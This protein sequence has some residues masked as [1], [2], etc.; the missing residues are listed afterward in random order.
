MYHISYFTINDFKDGTIYYSWD[1]T[2]F[3]RL[4][5]DGWID[6]VHIGKGRYRDHNKYKVSYK[7]KMLINRIYKMLIGEESIPESSKRNTILKRKSYIDKVYSQAI[8]KFNKQKEKQRAILTV[9]PTVSSTT[10]EVTYTASNPGNGD[11]IT[12]VVLRDF[13]SSPNTTS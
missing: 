6:K 7:G 2:R 11:I 12:V 9:T 5:R 3:Y 1:K 13:T 4:Q 10:G 8:K